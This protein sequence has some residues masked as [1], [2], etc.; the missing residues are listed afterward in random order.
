MKPLTVNEI[1]TKQDELEKKINSLLQT[2]EDEVEIQIEK[3][4]RKMSFDIER[5]FKISITLYNPFK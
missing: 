3:I 5:N 4:E 1:Q 2:F